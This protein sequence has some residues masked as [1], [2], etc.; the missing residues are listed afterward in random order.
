MTGAGGGRLRSPHGGVHVKRDRFEVC[1]VTRQRRGF[2]IVLRSESGSIAR[3]AER[4]ADAVR[5]GVIGTEVKLDLG[6]VVAALE[7]RRCDA[8]LDFAGGI[9][10]AE[11]VVQV[12][13]LV[14]GAVAQNERELLVVVRFA[15]LIIAHRDRY[16]IARSRRYR[17]L[18]RVV[19]I[20]VQSEQILV[21][22][23]VIR[24][25]ILLERQDLRLRSGDGR[26]VDRV[27]GLSVDRC[28]QKI[29]DYI[30]V[31][32]RSLDLGALRCN[33]EHRGGQGGYY[34]CDQH[35]CHEKSFHIIQ[36]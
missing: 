27:K 22:V 24:V 35:Q 15:G 12:A 11:F 20:D 30:A 6:D 7:R 4:P 32:E 33:G 29:V 10:D 26:E 31:V 13:V 34:E 18:S 3:K 8:R 23:H 5:G 21:F 9:G 25:A 16:L 19:D 28:S 17:L 14:R 1:D 2:V 36:R